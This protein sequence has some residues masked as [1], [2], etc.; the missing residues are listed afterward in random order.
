VTYPPAV[1]REHRP[2]GA[3]GRPGAPGAS[4]PTDSLHSWQTPGRGP[5]V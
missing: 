5:A 3:T 2:S 1:R 4:S